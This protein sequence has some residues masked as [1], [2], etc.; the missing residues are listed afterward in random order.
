MWYGS[1]D[2]ESRASCYSLPGVPTYSHVYENGEIEERY[3]ETPEWQFFKLAYKTF[4]DYFYSFGFAK[5]LN[6]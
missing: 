4:F 2:P 6:G 3:I 1:V 5:S